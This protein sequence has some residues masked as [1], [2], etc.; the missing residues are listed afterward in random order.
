MKK[1]VPIKSKTKKKF[2]RKAKTTKGMML[3]QKILWEE[4]EKF[5]NILI[6]KGCRLKN[7]KYKILLQ[8]RL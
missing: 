4:S 8:L 1:E 6:Q 3:S 5:K 7:K 2:K